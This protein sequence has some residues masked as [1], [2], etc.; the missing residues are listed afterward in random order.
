MPDLLLDLTHA[1]AADAQAVDLAG[2]WSVRTVSRLRDA[3]ALGWAVPR[4]FGG[5][6][7]DPQRHVRAYEAVAR[8]SLTAALILTQHD[9]ACQLIAKSE[10]AR[11]AEAVLPALASGAKLAT[12]GIS[13]LTTSM[14]LGR[15]ALHAEA[16]PGG[17]WRL[18]GAM[19][20][21]TSAP[22]CDLVL[23]GATLDD[24]RQLL[25]TLDPREPG[26][27]IGPPAELAALQASATCEIQ[28]DGV[29]VQSSQ[30]VRGPADDVLKRRAPV[31]SLTVTATAI[32]HAAAIVDALRAMPTSPG[33]PDAARIDAMLREFEATRNRV[34]EAAARRAEAESDPPSTDLRAEVNDLVNRLSLAL[35]AVRKGRGFMRDEPAQ[36]L[37]RE[38]MFFMV[39]SLPVEARGESLS[40]LVRPFT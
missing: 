30:L 29:I 13:H 9:G 12:V 34:L 37:A 23:A 32:G 25:C 38:A 24:G 39:W 7:F 11:L 1:L 33:E 28:C 3:G 21:V 31:K 8:G 26:V 20:W 27:R 40:R 15:S 6:E 16:V 19:P 18:R 35:L 2:A 36:R 17:A 5:G 14:R 4:R 10:N 22:C